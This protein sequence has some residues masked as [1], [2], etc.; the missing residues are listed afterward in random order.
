MVHRKPAIERPWLFVDRDQPAGGGQALVEGIKNLLRLGSVG[1]VSAADKGRIQRHLL[2]CLGF[3]KEEDAVGGTDH[4][5][6]PKPV[7]KAESRRE[8]M[9][10]GGDQRPGGQSRVAS[11][12][13]R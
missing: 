2:A 11:A 7:G 6:V 9:L 8:V 4:C 3:R 1:I 10:V 13:A 5:L 12:G